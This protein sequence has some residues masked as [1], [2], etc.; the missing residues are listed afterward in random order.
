[1][2]VTFTVLSTYRLQSSYNML[3]EIPPIFGWN[4]DRENSKKNGENP[5]L[6]VYSHDLRQEIQVSK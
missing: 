6:H 2:S 5:G 4:G 3:K 1:M